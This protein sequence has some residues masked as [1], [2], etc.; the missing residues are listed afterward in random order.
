MKEQRDQVMVSQIPDELV[1]YNALMARA[2]KQLKE[3]EAERGWYLEPDGA[4]V[5][6]NRDTFFTALP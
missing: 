2:L 4:G 3:L 1:R 6:Q 5:T